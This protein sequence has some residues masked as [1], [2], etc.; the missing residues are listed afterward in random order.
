MRAP[1]CPRCRVLEARLERERAAHRRKVEGL[2]RERGRAAQEATALHGMVEQLTGRVAELEAQ[3]GRHSGNSGKPPSSDTLTQ[4]AQQQEERLSRAER[5]RRARAKARQWLRRGEPKRRAGKQPGEPGRTLEMVAEPDHVL[6][7]T[8][9]RCRGCGASLADAPATGMERRQVF[10][11]PLIGPQVWEHRAERRRCRCGTATQGSFPPEATAPASYG[12][13]IRA[14][15]CYLLA[16]HHIPVER[17]AELLADM[18][19]VPVST[20]WCS[21]I[22]AEAARGLGGFLAEVADQL[23]GAEVL[24][25]DETG[26][27]IAGRRLWFHDACTPTLTLLDCHPRRG[28]EATRDMGVLPAFRGVAVHDRWK[29]LFTYTEAE[30]ALC[31]AHLLRDL[32]AVAEIPTQKTWAEGMADL[33]LDAKDAVEDASAKGR[34]CLSPR[35]LGKLSERY[36]QL[37]ADALAANPDPVDR[38]RTKPER[39]SY[40]LVRAFGTYKTEILRFAHDFRVPFDNNQAER[41]LRMTKLQQK[42]SGCFRTVGGAR[43]FCAVRSYLQTADKQGVNLLGALTRLFT[44]DPWI[45]ARARAP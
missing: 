6:T 24:H 40:N 45:P 21:G 36:D 32:A 13:R 30:H 44:G 4:R 8:P 29:P 43:A 34:T 27:R 38:G 17:T 39:D 1:E 35:R 41:D 33:L 3:L 12:P 7:H 25:V 11:L 28:V 20:G 22:T 16:R 9:Q 2:E 10:D 23:I 15:A 42:I 26:A 14:W 5:R 31:C 19:G 37:V 18:L